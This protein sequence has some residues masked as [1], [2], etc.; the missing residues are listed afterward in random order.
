[1]II[2]SNN[3]EHGGFIAMKPDEV[4]LGANHVS[5]FIFQDS[6][7]VGNEM[8]V[9]QSV[10]IGNEN[11]PQDEIILVPNS[12]IKQ[13]NIIE[14][15]GEVVVGSNVENEVI[16][17]DQID[18]HLESD[19]FV[20]G[21]SIEM[22]SDQIDD[23]TFEDT[24]LII[25]T[26]QYGLEEPQCVVGYDCSECGMIMKSSSALKK[27]IRTHHVQPTKGSK[28]KSKKSGQEERLLGGKRYTCPS[29]PYS[30]QRRDKLDRHM[31]KH[32][33]L[34]GVHPCGKKR[35]KPDTLPQR[36]R[37]NAEEYKCQFCP[38]C[39]TVYKALKKHRKVHTSDTQNF[40]L[41]L[42]CKICGKDR[43]TESDMQKHM[44]KHRNGKNF[45]CDICNFS[46][47]QLKKI[48]Q[49]RRM[50]TGEKPH[51]CPH[52]NYRSARRDNLRS[53]VRRM[54]KRENMYIDTFNPKEE[55]P[56]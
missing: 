21:S 12:M 51:L 33:L 35:H 5:Q 1:M 39:C 52:C 54:H 13:E 17:E 47:I 2:S 19:R 26:T 38:Y 41:K 29:C 56:D 42:S 7:G 10:E 8:I 4:V 16:I 9:E 27:H 25:D 40:T 28:G 53:H 24:K 50:H 46:S 45:L 20:I 36:H 22:G 49:H 37:H 11:D 18:A 15:G 48:I 34:D 30:T 43:V 3:I 32:V 23:A 55:S 44:K 14:E 31:Q 6:V